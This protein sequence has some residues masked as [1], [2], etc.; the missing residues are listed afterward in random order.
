MFPITREELG[1]IIR[2][3]RKAGKD[4]TELEKGLE[5]IDKTPD[6]VA[7]AK[8]KKRTV[9]KGEWV[10]FSTGPEVNEGDFG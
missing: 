4:T 5:L 9:Q 1:K 6:K 3:A 7:C 2:E 10:Y 8:H